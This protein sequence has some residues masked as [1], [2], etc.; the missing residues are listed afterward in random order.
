MDFIPD[1]FSFRNLFKF[2][3]P[4]VF[5]RFGVSIIAKSK[6]KNE[7]NAFQNQQATAEED[8]KKPAD[9]SEAIVVEEKEAPRGE[10][11]STPTN[12]QV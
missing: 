8:P 11:N 4:L 10:N 7:W 2:M 9:F 6:R 12:P 5:N 1:W 3:W